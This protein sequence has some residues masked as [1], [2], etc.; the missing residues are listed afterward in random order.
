MQ[1]PQQVNTVPLIGQQ[2]K[3]AEAQIKA[4]VNQLAMQIYTRVISEA[5]AH[6]PVTTAESLTCNDTGVQ[7]FA[8]ESLEAA[9]AYFIAIGAL[10]Q[11]EEE[12]QA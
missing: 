8:R 12:V 5:I 11:R 2:Q 1:P 9:K 6:Q 4:A 10:K 7:E 3:Q